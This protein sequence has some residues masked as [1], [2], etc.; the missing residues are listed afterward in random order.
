MKYTVGTRV[1][2]V[3]LTTGKSN[4][5]TDTALIGKTGT[6]VHCGTKRCYV[7]VP[8]VERPAGRPTAYLYITDVEPVLKLV[9]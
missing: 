8:G 6:I 4:D 2:I 5:E 7:D 9:K 3:K 1:R